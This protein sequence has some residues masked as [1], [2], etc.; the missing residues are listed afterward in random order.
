MIPLLAVPAAALV[1]AAAHG[2]ASH[3]WGPRLAAWLRHAPPPPPTPHHHRHL[4]RL[5]R[6]RH[7][8]RT[9]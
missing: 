1:L 4:A 3:G 5:A 9:R 8:R 2:L 7:P 6:A